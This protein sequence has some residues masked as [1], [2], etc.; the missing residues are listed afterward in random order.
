MQI[1]RLLPLAA[2]LL[3]AGCGTGRLT[4]AT[5]QTT[6]STT[7]QTTA[8]AAET[9]ATPAATTTQQTTAP[10]TEPTTAA[11]A[12]TTTEPTT[13]QTAA[14][15]VTE[16]WMLRLAN[17]THAVGEYAPPELT[18]LKNGVQVD[19]RMYPALQKMFDDMRAQGLTPFVREGYRTYAQQV[20]I[21]ETRIRSYKEQ[22]YSAA[23]AEKL[24]K[25]YVAEPG[26]SEHQL[27]LAVDIN[28]ESGNNWSVY[29]WLAAHAQEYGFI[30][31]YPQNGKAITGYEYEPWHYRYVGV[32]A[33]KE[34]Y[35]AKTTLEEY[36]GEQALREAS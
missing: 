26:T 23:Q 4:A 36:L 12:Q 28:A 7:Q 6:E 13:Q 18:E 11:T 10:A 34:I 32:E 8:S 9:T 27:G 30:L 20:D 16:N 2:M 22:G 1:R 3:L 25:D 21:M 33:A 15:T 31:R 14:V 35:A 19:A 5:E 17:K 29:N 24:A